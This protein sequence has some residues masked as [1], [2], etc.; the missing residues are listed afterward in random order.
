MLLFPGE[1]VESEDNIKEEILPVV[2]S[3]PVTNIQQSDY[4]ANLLLTAI[5][6]LNERFS[7]ETVTTPS[8]D[9]TVY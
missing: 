4:T 5:A 6:A 3:F 8:S 2:L 9:V 1:F 7:N